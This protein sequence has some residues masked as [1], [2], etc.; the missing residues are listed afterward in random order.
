MADFIFVDSFVEELAKGTHNLASDTFKVVLLTDANAP[1]RADETL[2]DLTIIDQ[3]NLDADTLTILTAVQT[4][5]VFNWVLQ[6]F[7]I[8]A[9]GGALPTFRWAAIY[10]DT[11]ANDEL[12]GFSDAGFDIDLEDQDEQLLDFSDS[13]GLIVMTLL[14]PE[15]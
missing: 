1:T 3:T 10:N 13:D 14:Q 11:A 7:I 15:P 4:D 9:D 8:K 5:G 12:V 2:S 6:D